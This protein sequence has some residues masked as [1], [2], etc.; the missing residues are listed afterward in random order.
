MVLMDHPHRIYVTKGARE[1]GE[2]DE[3][4]AA[5][6]PKPIDECRECSVGQ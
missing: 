5:S 6:V 4:G 2:E 3:K 1:E